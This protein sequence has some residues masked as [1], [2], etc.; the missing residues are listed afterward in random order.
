MEPIFRVE[1]SVRLGLVIVEYANEPRCEE[2]CLRGL[3]PGPTNAN[4]MGESEE[5]K[6]K[7]RDQ[8]LFKVCACFPM[9]R[10]HVFDQRSTFLSRAMQSYEPRHDAKT[11]RG[12][13]EADQRLCFR[14]L[15]STLPLLPKYKI[16]SPLARG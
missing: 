16:S 15:D 10:S 11:K 1:M 2:T 7:I 8:K 9:R 14:Y 6:K 12:N 3:R 4:K 13:R 5:K